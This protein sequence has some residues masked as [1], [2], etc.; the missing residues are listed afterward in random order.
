MQQE[1]GKEETASGSFPRPVLRV[2]KEHSAAR[3]QLA[4]HQL[5]IMPM[6]T[7]VPIT[8]GTHQNNTGHA[9][10]APGQALRERTEDL[11]KDQKLKYI[12][13]T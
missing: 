11:W 8:I 2:L 13:R 7:T 5:S 1:E 10:P 3:N 12:K 9:P 6:V 4:K